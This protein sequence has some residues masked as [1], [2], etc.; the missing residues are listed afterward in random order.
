MTG[1]RESKKRAVRKALYDAALTLI[2]RDGY[3]AVSV[4]QI[5]AA[6]GV[7]KGTFFNH[8]PGKADLIAEWYAD[9]IARTRIEPPGLTGAPLPRRLTALALRSSDLAAASPRMWQAKHMHAVAT[10][11][12][13]AAESLADQL[14][15]GDIA[16]MIAA[17]RDAGAL[18]ASTDAAAMA[19]LVVT[20]VTGSIREWLTSGQNGRLEDRVESRLSR[21]CALAG[22][23]PL[24]GEPEDR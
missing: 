3:D 17:A 16:G 15:A 6:A 2:E 5:V 12:V 1:K 19:D 24:A 7:A 22:Y 11:S 8:F 13:Q 23:Q 10:P 18:P 20:L 9:V 14:V 4:D 21:L